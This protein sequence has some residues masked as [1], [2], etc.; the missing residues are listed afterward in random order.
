VLPLTDALSTGY[1]GAEMCNLKGGE[2]V[3]VFGAGPV[4]LF[5]MRSA[6]LMGAGRVIAVDEVDYRL[7]FARSW[8]G[9]ETLNFREV[10]VVTAVKDVTEGRGADASIDA[11][12]C[13]AAGSAAQRVLGIYGKLQG[14]STVAFNWCVHATRKG[15]T[16]S[17]VGV[18]GPPFAAFDFG[19][20]MNKQQTIRTGQ[21]PV[22]RYMPHLLEHVRAGRIDP[23][24]IFTHRLPLDQAP[25]GYRTF[26]RKLDGCIK[27]ALLPHGATVH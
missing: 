15:G 11:V 25:E 4:G 13:E 23:K 20:A 1:F 24:P 16:V 10:D 2:T 27:V 3:V 7:E 14:G 18:Y 9:V 22:K 19:T 8:A 21:C 26:A 5:A 17:V 12:G 6:W